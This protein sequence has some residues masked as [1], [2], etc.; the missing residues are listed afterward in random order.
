MTHDA[1]PRASARTKP[2]SAAYLERAALYYLERYTSSSENLRRVL[3]RKACRRLEPGQDIDA[4]ITAMVGDVVER[5]L[6]AGLV[7]DNAYAYMKVNSLMRRG[8][9]TRTMRTKLLAK[10]VPDSAIT[11]AFESHEPDEMALARRY[12]ERKRLGPWRKGD[13]APFHAKD[14]AAMGR[15]GFAYGIARTILAGDP[16]DD[17]FADVD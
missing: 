14:M 13:P 5:V 4:E 3:L 9:S 10:G 2:L 16:S 17:D 7:D 8:A 15:A 11:T 12:A 6:R 1:P